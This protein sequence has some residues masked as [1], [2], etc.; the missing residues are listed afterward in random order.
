MALVSL[1]FQKRAQIDQLDLDVSISEQHD[2]TA[3]LTQYELEAGGNVNDH[4]ILN[5][6][7][8]IIEGVVSKTPLGSSALISS[9]ATAAGGALGKKIGGSNKILGAAAVVGGASIG[10]LVSNAF[11]LDAGVDTSKGKSRKPEDVYTY[12]VQ[13]RDKRQPFTVVTK[14]RTYLN[15]VLTSVS[16]PRTAASREILQFTATLEQVRIVEARAASGIAGTESALGT[17]AA[18]EQKLGKQAATA[19]APKTADNGSVALGI[20]KYAGAVK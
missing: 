6:I 3:T 16:A 8:L 19:A 5:P 2:A 4:I 18:P 17:A 15:M 20:L 11:G 14:L 13:L 12:L 7:K 9:A 10:G 1:F